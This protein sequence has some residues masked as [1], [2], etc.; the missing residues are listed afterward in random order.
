V[1]DRQR[2]HACWRGFV[3]QIE[4]EE[5]KVTEYDTHSAYCAAKL[6]GSKSINFHQFQEALRL[7]SSRRFP[8]EDA[9]RE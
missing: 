9:P 3:W 1:I 2:A 7:L 8:A 5:T 6:D 4:C